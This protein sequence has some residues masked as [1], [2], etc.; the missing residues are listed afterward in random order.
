MTTKS[1]TDRRHAPSSASVDPRIGREILETIRSISFGEVVVT[2]HDGRV[3][4]IEKKEKM[5]L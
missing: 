2:V 1:D 5:R 4:Q 3:V